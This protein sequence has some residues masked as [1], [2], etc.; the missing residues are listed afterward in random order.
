MIDLAHSMLEDT[1]EQQEISSSF[2]NF[3][4]SSSLVEVV[5]RPQPNHYYY[6]SFD[7]ASF[8]LTTVYSPQVNDDLRESFNNPMSAVL[9]MNP[10][11]IPTQAYVDAQRH[12]ETTYSPLINASLNRT[13]DDH[14]SALIHM[15]PGAAHRIFLSHDTDLI[16]IARE[17][18]DHLNYGTDHRLDP[19]RCRE[20]PLPPGYPGRN[21]QSGTTPT[22]ATVTPIIPAHDEDDG[23]ES[24][25]LDSDR[26]SDSPP[27]SSDT[28]PRRHY[29]RGGM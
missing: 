26:H 4:E 21:G 28:S 3:P 14:L 25:P 20:H 12:L 5:P 23:S 17:A 11:L 19:L 13:Y 18:E 22:P 10:R 15:D 29:P 27:V 7:S 1:D 9:F 6:S 8:F 2:L 16:S 24:V